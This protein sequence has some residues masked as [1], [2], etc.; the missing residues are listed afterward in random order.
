MAD[1]KIKATGIDQGEV[2]PSIQ[3]G[4]AEIVVKAAPVL[5][6]PVVITAQCS[7]AEILPV[8]TGAQVEDT[9]V[10]EVACINPGSNRLGLTSIDSKGRGV[11]ARKDKV[12]AA[13]KV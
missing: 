13:V 2:Y 12:A 10:V 6:A 4:I 3:G 7:Q 11:L 8:R 1:P 5:G 9:A